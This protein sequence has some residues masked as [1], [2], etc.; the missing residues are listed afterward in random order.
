[1]T[2]PQTHTQLPLEVAVLVSVMLHAATLGAWQYRQQLA[3][4]SPLA[5]LAEAL[6]RPVVRAPVRAADPG[7][8]ITF[9]AVPVVPEAPAAARVEPHIFIETD[10]RQPAAETV[11]D[12]AL[13][14]ERATVA[15]NPANPTGR[16]GDTPY[17]DGQDSPVLSSENVPLLT[18]PVPSR[19]DRGRDRPALPSLTARVR[20]GLELPAGRA[21]GETGRGAAGAAPSITADSA[22]DG[23]PD[24]R[25]A[26]SEP[27]GQPRKALPELGARAETAPSAAAGTKLTLAEVPRPAAPTTALR[28]PAAVAATATASPGGREIAAV[29]SRQV[30]IGLD[31]EGVAAFNVAAS[32]FGSYD[33]Q[34]IRA[35][36]S[37]W[38]RLVDE[39]NIV[40]RAGTVRLS[41]QLYADGRISTLQRQENTAGEILALYCEKAI[42]DNVPFEPLPEP[43]RVLRG[44][45]PR[46]VNFTFYY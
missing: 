13:Y 14:S 11:P 36:Q 18:T 35:V 39:Y 28:S 32:P 5:R 46:A 8:T 26:V 38:L 4:F 7:Q 12:T 1:M 21:P 19:S 3:R 2:R 15:A 40:A 30:E 10:D 6:R 25:R 27:A 41:F 9:V 24:S 22:P 16:T 33:K 34:L 45:E 37:K 44:D 31:R 17:L 42:L 29:K 43:L 20:P 23:R